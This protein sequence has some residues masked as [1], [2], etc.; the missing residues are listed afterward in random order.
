M[1]ALVVLACLAALTAALAGC[2]GAGAGG[3]STSA[4]ARAASKRTPRQIVDAAANALGAVTSYRV[5]GTSTDKDGQTAISADI[6]AA[7]DYRLHLNTAGDVADLLQVRGRTYLRA[8]AGFWN[9]QGGATSGGRAAQLFA[10]RWIV[11]PPVQAAAMS[12]IV[13]EVRPRTL[14]YC[15][16][17]P[18]GTLTNRG[19]RS[20]AG[21]DAIVIADKGDRPGDAPGEL[22]IAASGRPRP[23]RAVQS[24]PTPPG[25]TFDPRCDSKGDTTT[26]SDLRFSRFDEPVHVTAPHGA[27]SLPGAGNVT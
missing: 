6:S 12:T 20:F 9:R 7:G 3:S 11:L 18:T 26:A 22:W 2:G 5:E 14:A 15:A 17:R 10:G 19:R 21:A 4:A 27:I 16:R 24:G 13:A 1:R 8:N 25:G 23:V